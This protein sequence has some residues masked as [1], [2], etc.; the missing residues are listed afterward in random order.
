MKEI[1]K[2]D[3]L[4]WSWDLSYILHLIKVLVHSPHDF[5]EVSGKGLAI[6]VGQESFISVTGEYIHRLVGNVLLDLRII[7]YKFKLVC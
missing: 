5:P 2:I 7:D 6:G 1:I 4:K 3:G